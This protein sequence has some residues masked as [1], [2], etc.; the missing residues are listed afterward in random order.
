MPTS[1]APHR[2]QLCVLHSILP[3]FSGCEDIWSKHLTNSTSPTP[4]WTARFDIYVRFPECGQLLRNWSKIDTSKKSTL[5]GQLPGVFQITRQLFHEATLI[6]LNSCYVESWNT[7]TSQTLLNL[8]FQFS[9]NEATKDVKLISIYDW[10]EEGTAV[11]LQLISK[12]TNLES[13]KM[14]FS[15]LSIIDGT[16]M[17]KYN[18]PNEQV[19][20]R[21][22]GLHY[23]PPQN[24]S[25]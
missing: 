7:Q 4:S 21:E 15:F 11:Q 13:L 17:N 19:F 2:G 16:L 5:S 23:E 22:T 14:S 24:R 10:K 18:Y 20:W 25:I 8:Y 6:F 9:D 12:F 3:Q 1:R